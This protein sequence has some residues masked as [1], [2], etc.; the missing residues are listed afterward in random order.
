MDNKH[1]HSRQDNHWLHVAAARMLQ[2]LVLSR[3]CALLNPQC[4]H[5]VNTKEERTC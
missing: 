4:N 3:F 5:C 2:T 1:Q